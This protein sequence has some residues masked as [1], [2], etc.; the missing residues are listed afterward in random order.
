MNHVRLRRIAVVALV[1]AVLV[2]AT[3]SVRHHAF[4][5]AVGGKDPG[6]PTSDAKAQMPGVVAETE[7]PPRAKAVAVVTQHAAAA[8]GDACGQALRA[9][10]ATRAEQLSSG[11]D[12]RDRLAGVILGVGNDFPGNQ[13]AFDRELELAV[14]QH[15]DD[16]LLRW[17]HATRCLESEKCNEAAILESLRQLD[18]GNSAP[19]LL[20]LDA[21]MKRDD[22]AR[23][24]VLL[25]EAARQAR[26]DVYWGRLPKHIVEVVGPAGDV[27]ACD[28]AAAGNPHDLDVPRTLQ[29]N[30]E[31]FAGAIG[32]AQAIP[33]GVLRL[34]PLSGIPQAR[35]PA[36]RAMFAQM[37]AN[38]TLLL[39][40][41][42][43]KGMLKNASTPAERAHWGEVVRNV[44]WMK[45]EGYPLLRTARQSL[46][47]EHG[48][49]PVLIALLEGEGRWPAPKDW[50]PDVPVH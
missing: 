49:V 16:T 50:Q 23:A 27:P 15:P 48:E 17:L 9:L 7:T 8:N 22:L 3:L 30:V 42:G 38:D 43:A 19:Y 26:V 13:R 14:A 33:L 36:C 18:P 28:R 11:A 47:W 39:H 35:L 20:A 4:G 29:E 34:C 6:Q 45:R 41:I 2:A 44:E 31:V 1:G 21:A 25:A 10:L 5:R 46:V 12:A 40:A 32:A 24:E 37:A